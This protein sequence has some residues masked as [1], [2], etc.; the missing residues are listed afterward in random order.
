MT[1]EEI[2]ALLIAALPSL[3]SIIGAIVVFVKTKILNNH[4]IE[5]IK[6]HTDYKD[7]TNALKEL[8]ERFKE[9]DQRLDEQIAVNNELKRENMRIQAKLNNEY[10]EEG[11]VDVRDN[12][13]V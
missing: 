12:K 9:L 4:T 6:K 7:L 10:F 5:D 1:L 2:E 13:E 11:A 3:T 8:T